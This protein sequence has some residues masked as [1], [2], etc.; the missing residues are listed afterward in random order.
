MN[1]IKE[2][3]NKLWN[4]LPSTEKILNIVKIFL[5]I[6]L[7]IICFV[8]VYFLI[9]YLKTNNKK[10]QIHPEF[11]IIDVE[12]NSD[13]KDNGDLEEAIKIGKDVLE[14]INKKDNEGKK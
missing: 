11:K 14:K 3:F 7:A 12:N 1:K 10:I 9:K 2:F 13:V 8:P 5:F 6:F 4:G